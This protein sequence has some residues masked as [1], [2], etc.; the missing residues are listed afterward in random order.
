[1][2]I[3]GGALPLSDVE[4]EFIHYKDCFAGKI[5]YCPS[6]EVKNVGNPLDSSNSSLFRYF[7][8]QFSRL[9]LKALVCS[10]TTDESPDLVNC[11][12][13]T[14]P[15]EVE[16]FQFPVRGSVDAFIGKMIKA[17]GIVVSCPQ[18][19]TART[20]IR[21]ISQN[22]GS[23]ILALPQTAL[24]QKDIFPLIMNDKAKVGKTFPKVG[25]WLTNT[26]MD[27][28]PH[29]TALWNKYAEGKFQKYCNLENAIDVPKYDEIPPD[30]PGLV[31]TSTNFLLRYNPSQFK[32][33]GLG[34][35][36]FFESIPGATKISEEFAAKYAD[37]GA[38]TPCRAGQ[39]TL[40][41]YDAS[42]VARTATGRVIIQLRKYA[43][44]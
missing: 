28:R 34:S 23:F 5:V 20:I 32:I 25:M 29:P 24:V 41:Y 30:W 36:S 4:G 17:S 21:E 42:G 10:W 13:C 40:G 7:H 27:S 37:S 16:V 1:M 35:G 43:G 8:E 12:K 15:G 39:P 44:D 33:L 3:S 26:K 19:P 6:S 9:G 2:P 22:G 14:K 18:M 31:G 11:C 38:K